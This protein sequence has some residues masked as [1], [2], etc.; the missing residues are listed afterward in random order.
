M[1]GEFEAAGAM[2]CTIA[3]QTPE[4]AMEMT[5]KNRVEFPMLSD[6]GNTVAQM[7]GLRMTVPGDLH[8]VY[9]S[10]GIDLPAFNG[11]ESLTLPI[12]ARLI[13]D[14]TGIIRDVDADLDYTIRPEPSDTLERLERLSASPPA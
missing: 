2:L 4:H 6:Q 8:E 14:P 5:R 1:K 3:P 7:Y 12:P 13:I 10:F 11:D 9:K